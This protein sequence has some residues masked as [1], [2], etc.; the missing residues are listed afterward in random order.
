MRLGLATLRLAQDE[1]QAAAAALAPVIDGSA[2]LPWP[3]W[4]AQAFLLEAIARAA[5]GDPRVAAQ[6]L[7]RALDLTEPD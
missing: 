4:L 5:L 7:E 2:Q 1:P 3:G 6:A